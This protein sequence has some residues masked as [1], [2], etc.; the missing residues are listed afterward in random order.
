M[1]LL[2][3]SCCLVSVLVFPCSE[4]IIW[5]LGFLDHALGSGVIGF[6]IRVQ[7]F[8]VFGLRGCGA[9]ECRGFIV[10]AEG[11]RVAGLGFEDNLHLLNPNPQPQTPWQPYSQLGRSWES[12][13]KGAEEVLLG[14]LVQ[15]P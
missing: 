4:T 10:G 7:G 14:L 11:C 12:S 2:T 6:R 1:V 9:I 5:G 8:R 15:C 3:G 13:L